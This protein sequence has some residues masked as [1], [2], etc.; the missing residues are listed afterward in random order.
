VIDWR[1]AKRFIPDATPDLE[2]LQLAADD[3]RALVS[4]DAK[5]MPRHFATFV[6][7]H[8]SPG[9]ILIPTNV[10]IGDAIEGLLMLWLSL[11]AEDIENQIWWLPR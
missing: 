4:R 8:S 11:A 2:V 3:G 6:A 5:T 9:A 10:T 1:P 7:T